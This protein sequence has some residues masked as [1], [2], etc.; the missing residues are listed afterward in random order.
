MSSLIFALVWIIIGAALFI[1]GLKR[2]PGLYMYASFGFFAAAFAAFFRIPIFLQLFAGANIMLMAMILEESGP[3]KLFIIDVVC[4]IA[5][6]TYIIF[7][8]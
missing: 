3:N 5:L 2:P 7:I 1:Y 8:F 6:W 4:N